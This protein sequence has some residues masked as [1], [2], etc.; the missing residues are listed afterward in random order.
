MLQTV[1]TFSDERILARPSESAVDFTDQFHV[2]QE[3]VE[4]IEVGEAHHVRGAATCCL[5][6]HIQLNLSQ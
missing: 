1:H 3:R 5:R 2:V 4:S 6:G